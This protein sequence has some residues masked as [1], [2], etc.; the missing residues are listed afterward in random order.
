MG[1]VYGALL[2][3]MELD[4]FKVFEKDYRLNR[5]EKAGRISAQL[6]KIFLN[7]PRQASV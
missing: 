2:R 6:F 3:R 1:S 7:S 5:L 4:N